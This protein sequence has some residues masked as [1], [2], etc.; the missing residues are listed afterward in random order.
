M[1]TT[2]EVLS[3]TL[4]LLCFATGCATLPTTVDHRS[5]GRQ[6]QPPNY[7]QRGGTPG[8]WAG[9]LIDDEEC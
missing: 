4:C 6:A 3:V 7:D 1:G 9:A 8:T 2:S 5:D